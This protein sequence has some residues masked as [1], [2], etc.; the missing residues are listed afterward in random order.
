MPGRRPLRT[1]V[2]WRCGERRTNDF[3]FFWRF[4][5][6]AETRACVLALATG[7]SVGVGWARVPF[8]RPADFAAP[9]PGQL[10]GSVWLIWAAFAQ[11]KVRYIVTKLWILGCTQ[12]MPTQTVQMTRGLRVQSNRA[13]GLMSSLMSS[14]LSPGPTT[15]HP[16]PSPAHTRARY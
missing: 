11:T 3:A 10:L 13:H 2:G 6:E 4:G 1:I 5:R 9:P 14:I 16:T 8:G 12:L 15:H 7:V